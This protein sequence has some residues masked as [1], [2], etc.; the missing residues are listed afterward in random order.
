ML[1]KAKILVLDE[2]TASV[3]AE[4]DN[5]IQKMINT[6]FEHKTVLTIAH[7]LHTL[8]RADRILVLNGGKLAEQGTP[9]DLMADSTT[10]FAQM[11]AEGGE[12]NIARVWEILDA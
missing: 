9:R 5:R 7:R 12:K 1:S 2:A 8:A 4:T 10:S 3:D 11:V 6:E